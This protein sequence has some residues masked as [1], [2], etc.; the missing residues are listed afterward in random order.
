MLHFVSLITLGCSQTK[1]NHFHDTKLHNEDQSQEWV[2]RLLTAADSAGL[3]NKR[4]SS[5][6]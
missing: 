1:A 5:V 2:S 4:C 6:H 3:Q